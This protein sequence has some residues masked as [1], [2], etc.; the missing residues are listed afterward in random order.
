MKKENLKRAKR[1]RAMLVL[2][3]GPLNGGQLTMPSII[4]VLTDLRHLCDTECLDFAV[5]DRTA[6]AH[7]LEELT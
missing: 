4:G 2:V 6:Y 5:M 1:A 7:Y 3:Y